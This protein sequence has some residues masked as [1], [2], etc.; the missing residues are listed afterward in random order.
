MEKNEKMIS[1][2]DYY[3]V[4][5]NI[6][7]LRRIYRERQEDLADAIG[8][9]KAAIANY[10]NWHRIPSREDL[11]AISKHYNIS[12]SALMKG[13]FSK[14][15]TP[16]NWY[17]N[18][19]ELQEYILS[20]IFPFVCSDE[21]MENPNFQKAEQLHEELVSILFS[22]PD[23]LSDSRVNECIEL[24]EKAQDDGVVDAAVGLIWWAM[25]AAVGFSFMSK[26]Q[27]D[28]E[29]QMSQETTLFDYIH[30]VFLNSIDDEEDKT[31]EEEKKEDLKG[32]RKDILQQIYYLKNSCHDQLSALGDYYIAICYLYN[33]LDD[34][35]SSVRNR[36]IGF[37]MLRLYCTI[38][39]E[40]AN[41]FFELFDFLNN[42]N[43]EDETE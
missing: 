24:Y 4:G 1:Q 35:L 21:A 19:Q 9:T 39:N 10:E 31:I 23:L 12:V 16:A 30:K 7:E 18:D 3:K 42:L 2:K 20:I 22:N 33:I 15:S 27:K 26:K 43:N 32:L 14:V 5:E 11:F 41:E 13:D 38:H 37:S 40:Y 8:V 25:V 6:K 34:S 29:A 36:M 17:M 28:F